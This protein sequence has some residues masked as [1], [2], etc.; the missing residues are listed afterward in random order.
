MVAIIAIIIACGRHKLLM[1]NP[2][3]GPMRS[4]ACASKAHATI[5]EGKA[6]FLS[7]TSWDN[8]AAR[9]LC[10]LHGSPYA[11]VQDSPS[12]VLVVTHSAVLRVGE[13]GNLETLAH[14]PVPPPVVTSVVIAADRTI[15]MGVPG[16][17]TVAS[18]THRL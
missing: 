18:T 7:D 16:H 13:S 6:W 10:D 14:I 2:G 11:S 9:L 1:W 15:Y 3:T 4:C 12:T 8:A 17:T 5:D